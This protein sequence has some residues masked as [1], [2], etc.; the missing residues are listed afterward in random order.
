[1]CGGG[2]SQYDCDVFLCLIS[3][4]SVA[5]LVT[6]VLWTSV[7]IL[8]RRGH[9]I[10]GKKM[11][12]LKL[13][14]HV[15]L[16]ITSMAS[17]AASVAGFASL[18]VEDLTLGFILVSFFP[19]YILYNCLYGCCSDQQKSESASEP[20]GHETSSRAEQLEDMRRF[21]AEGIARRAAYAAACPAPL[22]C[23]SPGCLWST[24]QGWQTCPPWWS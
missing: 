7:I 3:V 24:P 23:S 22:S 16:A 1:M 21:R 15:F 8:E 12:K 11:K 10:A 5:L 17:F 2:N 6:S 14:F 20:V 13:I 4:L 19:A 9:S 18:L